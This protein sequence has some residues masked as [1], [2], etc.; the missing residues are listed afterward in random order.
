MTDKRL[1][2]G[3]LVQRKNNPGVP[4]GPIFAM[5]NEEVV[6]LVQPIGHFTE[7]GTI[8][9]EFDLPVEQKTVSLDE[10]ELYVPRGAGKA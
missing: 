10:I 4:M 9:I 7:A 1:Q 2:P 8:R 5:G 6:V 3:D